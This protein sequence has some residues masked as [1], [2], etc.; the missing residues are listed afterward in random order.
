MC[1]HE[2]RTW[3]IGFWRKL[4]WFQHG[5]L[6]TWIDHGW[7]WKLG[8]SGK[9]LQWYL[10]FDQNWFPKKF[11]NITF[12]TQKRRI[13]TIVQTATFEIISCLSCLQHWRTWKAK[14]FYGLV[15]T[16]K[17][18]DLIEPF[19]NRHE[20]SDLWGAAP[21][22]LCTGNAW[23]GCDR[24]GSGTNYINPI[25]SARLRTVNSFNIKYARLEIEAQLPRGDWLWPAIWM[26]PK[27]LSYGKWPSSGEI[28]IMLV[29]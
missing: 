2:C 26:L 24:V 12:K 25:N 5:H 27:H 21:S 20:N 14:A 4:G 10:R 23:W 11:E 13:I 9:S 8:I 29:F 19:Q 15:I 18:N 1:H 7:W 6:G 28:D 17:K 16:V 22:D 3:G